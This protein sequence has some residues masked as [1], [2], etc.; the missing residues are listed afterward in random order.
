MNQF[1]DTSYMMD[2]L[3]KSTVGEYTELYLSHLAG[4]RVSD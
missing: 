4:L 3:A 2:E 1:P